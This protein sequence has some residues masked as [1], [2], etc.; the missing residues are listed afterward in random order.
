MKDQFSKEQDKVSQEISKIKDDESNKL[1]DQ[2]PKL[3]LFNQM[4]ESAKQSIYNSGL[5][6]Y[7]TQIEAKS[8]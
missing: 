1:K 5:S 2:T 8:K 7:K 3:E 6:E 4:T